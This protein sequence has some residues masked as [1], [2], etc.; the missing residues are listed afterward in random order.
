MVAVFVRSLL[1]QKFFLMSSTGMHNK[2]TEKVI[3]SKILFFDSNPSGR[4]ITR[5]MKD[6]ALLDFLLPA[7][8]AIVT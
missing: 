3:R 7:L 1:L 2:M 6:M 4:I 5:F 8:I